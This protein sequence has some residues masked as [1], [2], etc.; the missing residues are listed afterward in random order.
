MENEK[1]FPRMKWGVSI[2]MSLVYSFG[3]AWFYYPPAKGEPLID[4]TFEELLLH[5]LVL[6]F[7]FWIVAIPGIE[8]KDKTAD[9]I[10]LTV[11]TLPAGVFAALLVLFILRGLGIETYGVEYF[12]LPLVPFTLAHKAVEGRITPRPSLRAFA[13]KVIAFAWGNFA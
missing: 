8:K 12:I 6:I 3:A 1:G 2:P 5:F 4:V 13:Y 10:L 11:L 9:L 7:L